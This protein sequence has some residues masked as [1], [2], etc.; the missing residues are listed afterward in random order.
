MNKPVKKEADG[1]NTPQKKKK[2]KTTNQLMH[3]H[4]QDKDHTITAEDIESLDLNL[5]HP[6]TTPPPPELLVPSEDDRPEEEKK[7]AKEELEKKQITP[8]DVLG[9]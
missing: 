5:G 9:G 1:K 4:L 7:A 6:Q 8:W 3:M 2:G